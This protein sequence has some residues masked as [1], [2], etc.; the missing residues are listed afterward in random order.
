MN[1]VS[2]VTKKK[3][4]AVVNFIFLFFEWLLLKLVN[5]WNYEL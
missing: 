2:D 3:L 1:Y 5:L 4:I